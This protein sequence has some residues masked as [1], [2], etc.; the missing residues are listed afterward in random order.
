MNKKFLVQ[1]IAI[2]IVIFCGLLSVFN[3][4][5]F[6]LSSIVPG[7]GTPGVGSMIED[8]SKIQILFVDAQSNGTPELIKSIIVADIADNP[9]ER[10]KGL[11]YRESMAE[12]EGMLFIFEQSFIPRFI[13]REMRFPLDFV[14]ID[15]DVI[16]DLLENIPA[17]APGTD[18][19]AMKTYSPSKAVDKVIELNAG[20]IKKYNLKVGD[21]I[22]AEQIATSSG[23][24]VQ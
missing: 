6:G 12:Q 2:L 5:L 14:W 3:P 23:S 17:E 4:A 16:V 22:R 21:R 7:G 19:A 8:T 20:Y 11:S 15:G 1:I 10:A 13:M 24:F 18:D 9:T